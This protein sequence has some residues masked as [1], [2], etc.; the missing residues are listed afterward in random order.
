MDNFS[1]HISFHNDNRK[2]TESSATFYTNVSNSE[3]MMTEIQLMLKRRER[4]S[5]CDLLVS[6]SSS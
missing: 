3:V 6:L 5:N 4:Q 2:I 1:W